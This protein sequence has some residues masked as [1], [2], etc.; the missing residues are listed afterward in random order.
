MKPAESRT[1]GTP[2][3]LMNAILGPS[4]QS[5]STPHVGSLVCSFV[6]H[7]VSHLLEGLNPSNALVFSKINGELEVSSY[8]GYYMEMYKPRG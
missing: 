1:Q 8:P 3:W 2:G 5:H 6:L 7:T 4:F